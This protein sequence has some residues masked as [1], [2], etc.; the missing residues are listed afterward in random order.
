M[1]FW[2]RKKYNVAVNTVRQ[3]E[4]IHFVA[5]MCRSHVLHHQSCELMK[6]GENI[7]WEGGTKNAKGILLVDVLA[8]VHKTTLYPWKIGWH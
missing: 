1:K 6:R 4:P 3:S 8:A 5:V 2:H 7:F